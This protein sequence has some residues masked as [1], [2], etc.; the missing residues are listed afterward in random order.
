[1]VSLDCSSLVIHSDSKWLWEMRSSWKVII[2]FSPFAFLLLSFIISTLN[3]L[4]WNWF[5]FLVGVVSFLLNHLV[6]PVDSVVV[7]LE[8][9]NMP[10]EELMVFLHHLKSD[11]LDIAWCNQTLIF[12]F[13]L[14]N[15]SF[16]VFKVSFQR[17]AFTVPEVDLVSVLDCWLLHQAK[18]C[19]ELLSFSLFVKQTSFKFWDS[20]KENS[21]VGIICTPQMV[22]MLTLLPH[23]LVFQFELLQLFLK[24]LV[25]LSLFFLEGLLEFGILI[26]FGLMVFQNLEAI[27]KV[28]SNNR[29]LEGQV[30]YFLLK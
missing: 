15:V 3:G 23:L 14:L 30:L 9:S 7:F 25:V 1:M 2:N 6:H 24:M 10:L 12:F 13:E 8:S 29:V 17:S 4:W 18:L 28:S 5:G 11:S 27:L 22:C 19:L 21:F 16:R 26:C 20:C